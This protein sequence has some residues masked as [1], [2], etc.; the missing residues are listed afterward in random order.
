MV[1][2]LIAVAA[3]PCM[4]CT[5][6]MGVVIDPPPV[7]RA[8]TNT[9]S[10]E[11]EFFNIQ[12]QVRSPVSRPISIEDFQVFHPTQYPVGRIYKQAHRN[13]RMIRRIHSIHQPGRT[14]CTQRNQGNK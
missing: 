1:L 9:V 4:S 11:E 6:V 13:G 12:E 7:N 8:P 3:P 2:V 5:A 14:N 10:V